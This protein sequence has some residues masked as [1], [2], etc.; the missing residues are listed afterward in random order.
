M[1]IPHGSYGNHGH[2]AKQTHQH[3]AEDMLNPESQPCGTAENTDKLS[4]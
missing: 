3:K 4:V 1:L 2:D